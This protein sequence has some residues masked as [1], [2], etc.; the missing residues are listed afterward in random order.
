M[1]YICVKPFKGVAEGETV[2]ETKG[3]LFHGDKVLCYSS[4]QN[5]YDH[6]AKNGDG[7][8]QERHA[9]IQSILG[10]ITA[11]AKAH[12]DAC[13]PIM[14]NAELTEEE[15]EAQISEVED[16]SLAA[17]ALA[18]KKGFRTHGTFNFEF[19]NATIRSLRALDDAI[20]ELGGENDG[21]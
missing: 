1:E 5:A 11:L 12:S 2:T 6:F 21:E 10:K 15:R 16:L 20:S 17:L 8:G 13:R 7:K 19:H 4:S 18:D 9:L 3:K 14:E